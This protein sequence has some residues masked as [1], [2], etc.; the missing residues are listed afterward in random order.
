MTI[1]RTIKDTFENLKNFKF[2]FIISQWFKFLLKQNKSVSFG[3]E[4]LLFQ[5]KRFDV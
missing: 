2:V 4:S 3:E 5:L 1:S